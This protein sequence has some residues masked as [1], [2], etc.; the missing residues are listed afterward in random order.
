MVA[1][2]SFLLFGER[3]GRLHLAAL[4]LALGGVGLLLG[5]RGAG[6]AGSPTR[7]KT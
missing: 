6:S 7:A 3:F 4:A 2:A 1:A 5:G